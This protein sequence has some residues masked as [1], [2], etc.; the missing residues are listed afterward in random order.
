MGGGFVD[1]AWNSSSCV[2]GGGGGYTNETPCCLSSEF[3][4]ASHL[5]LTLCLS[6]FESRGQ[7]DPK[8]DF[9]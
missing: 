4:D 8:L 3:W 7:A 6:V 9:R 5:G 2:I 1:T